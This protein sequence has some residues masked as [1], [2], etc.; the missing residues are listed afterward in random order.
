MEFVITK[1]WLLFIGD[2]TEVLGGAKLNKK[3]AER[4]DIQSLP[5][6]LADIG[7]DLNSAPL[8]QPCVG[9]HMQSCC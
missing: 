8:F 6:M 2:I 4:G 7:F 9:Y 3:L 1:K 5:V